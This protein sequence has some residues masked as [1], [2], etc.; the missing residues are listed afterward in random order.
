MPEPRRGE[1]IFNRARVLR[2]RRRSMLS[3]KS[4]AVKKNLLRLH[5]KPRKSKNEKNQNG[6]RH[7]H[8]SQSYSKSGK[9]Q[10]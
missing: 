10:D 9:H 7:V 4:D 1:N 3:L 6:Y 5:S 8:H 2:E